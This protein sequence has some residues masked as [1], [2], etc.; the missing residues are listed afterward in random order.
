MLQLIQKYRRKKNKTHNLYLTSIG[1]GLE[2]RATKS[3]DGEG[4]NRDRNSH[5][6]ADVSRDVNSVRR[7]LQAEEN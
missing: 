5:P 6:Q 2:T 3:V 7:A 1:D 4:W